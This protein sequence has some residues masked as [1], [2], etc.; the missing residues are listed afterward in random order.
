MNVYTMENWKL[1]EVMDMLNKV[2]ERQ[3]TKYK[4]LF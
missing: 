3:D 4:R 1:D 2:M